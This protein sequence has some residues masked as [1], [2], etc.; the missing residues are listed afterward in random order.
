MLIQSK[1]SPIKIS[2][3]QVQ[4]L[5]KGEIDK[6]IK[7]SFGEISEINSNNI[8]LFLQQLK[9]V[10]DNYLIEYDKNWARFELSF[11]IKNRIL[12]KS[13]G[14]KT[15]SAYIKLKN[16]QGDELIAKDFIRTLEKGNI[17]LEYIRQVLTNQIITTNFTIKGSEN[18]IYFSEKS[19][20]PYT[21]V[22][23]TYGSSG[24]NFFSLAYN[25][26]V[27]NAIK[28]LQENI[29]QE[30]YKVTGTDVYSRIMQ[31]K[32]GYLE[33]L[34][35]KN[36]KKAKSYVPR[37]DSTDAE[38]FNLMNQRLKNG[39]LNELNK[40]LTVAAYTRMRREMGG[41]GGYRTSQTQLGDV[42]L[43]QDKMISQ[44]INQV[45][46]ARQT[47]IR[48][49]FSDLEK[50]LSSMNNREI[51]NTFLKLFTEKQSRINDNISK[52]ANREAV[53]NIK[54]L[55]NGIK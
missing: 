15:S 39:D 12:S 5:T 32:D 1:L 20:I 53:K 35:K 43:I 22:L 41:R 8:L 45:N 31:V 51:K 33:V 50:A 10:I 44:R 52:M 55:F 13:D 18:E 2:E 23:S 21:L 17:L 4:P 54:E 38:I 16:Q 30:Q 46:F 37:Y 3:I 28:S 49:R 9:I 36:P 29:E 6:I 7:E 40:A 34:K 11:H 24:N 42:G 27:N 19:N 14:E 47:L 25:I 26:D 48:N